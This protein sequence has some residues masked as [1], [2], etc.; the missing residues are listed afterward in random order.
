[1]FLKKKFCYVTKCYFNIT[2]P[3]Y[4]LFLGLVETSVLLYFLLMGFL[5][6]VCIRKKKRE[7]ETSTLSSE[8][9][10]I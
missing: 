4:Y 3:H 6:L 2:S 10:G 1:M 8:L 9:Q 5:H 7:I